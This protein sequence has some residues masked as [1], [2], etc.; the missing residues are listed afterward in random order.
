M[1]D[2]RRTIHQVMLV[3]RISGTR[4]ILCELI[5]GLSGAIGPRDAQIFLVVHI[6]RVASLVE[7]VYLM[8]SGGI[9]C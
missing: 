5:Y 9:S 7:R 8:G 2:G 4:S 1:S 3:L 6:P